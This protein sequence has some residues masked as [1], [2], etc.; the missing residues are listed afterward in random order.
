MSSLADLIFPSGGPR[1]GY[2]LRLELV[3]SWESQFLG[4]GRLTAFLTPRL[5]AEAHA[6]DDMGVNVVFLQR[7]RIEVGLKLILERAQADPVGDHRL[8]VLWKRCDQACAAAGFSSQWH[9]FVRAQKDFVDLLNRVDPGAATFRYPVDTDNQPWKRGQVDLAELEQAGAAFQQDVLSL[10]RELATAEPLPVTAGE[11]AQAADELRSLIDGCRGMLRV[12]RETVDELRRHLDMLRSLRPAPLRSQRDTGQD[13]Y[14]ELAAVAEVTEPLATRAQDLLDRII[15]TYGIK[16]T[17]APPPPPVA[18]AP[19]LNP[20]DDPK[21][22]KAT[23]DA[24]IKWFVDHFVREIRPLTKAV[25][26]IYRRSQ[27]WSTPAARQIHLEVTRF[28]S[29]LITSEEQRTNRTS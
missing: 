22:I 18:P 20:F 24:Q 7:H 27:G 17:P 5:L 14:A 16:M 1:D 15:A 29:R 25:N 9:T 11:A 28:R 23:Q 2:I 26:A 19:M 4:L 10:V 6:V 3:G 21:T 8:D 12:S 13:S